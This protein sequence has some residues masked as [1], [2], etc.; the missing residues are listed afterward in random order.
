MNVTLA[1][2]SSVFPEISKTETSYVSIV[3]KSEVPKGEYDFLEM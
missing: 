1:C 3:E 2:F